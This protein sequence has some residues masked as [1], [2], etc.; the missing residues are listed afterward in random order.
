M[1]R[2]QRPTSLKSTQIIKTGKGSCGLSLDDSCGYL[3]AGI[4]HFFESVPRFFAP[5]NYIPF[6][7]PIVSQD[8]KDFASLGFP[9]CH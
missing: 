6:K 4:N 1:K 5:G 8:L 7:P 9:K 2:I 3:F